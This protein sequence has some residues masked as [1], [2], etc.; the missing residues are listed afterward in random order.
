MAIPVTNQSLEISLKPDFSEI[1]LIH[2]QRYN[3]SFPER[4]IYNS[5]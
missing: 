1:L 4:W 5:C 2:K 3:N